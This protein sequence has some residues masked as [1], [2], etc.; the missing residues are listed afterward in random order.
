MKLKTAAVATGFIAAAL[1]G[2]PSAHAYTNAE[3]TE[4]ICGVLDQFP[5][6]SG[7]KGVVE[8][9]LTTYGYTPRQAAVA[10]MGAVK[11]QCPEHRPE[12]SGF[13]TRFSS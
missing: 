5:T 8:S 13:I 11:D 10:V 7:V 9:L 2:T 12:V 1:I 3:M 4:A 6:V